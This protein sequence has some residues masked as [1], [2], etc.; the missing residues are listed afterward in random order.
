V[1]I[2]EGTAE[3]AA[4]IPVS[5]PRIAGGMG[6]HEQNWIAAIRGDARA[7]SPFAEAAPLNETMLLG[8]VA[9]RA[10]QPI[11]YDGAAGRITNMDG[12]RLMTRDYRAG[13]SL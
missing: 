13:W 6:G 11:E 3:R 10:G 12:E 8:M 2:G 9:L 1:L 7:S 5:L 4:A